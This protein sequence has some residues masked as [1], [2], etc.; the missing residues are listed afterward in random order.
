MPGLDAFS[1][2]SGTLALA[3]QIHDFF[4]NQL[5]DVP[6]NALILSIR[7]DSS[8]LN[9]FARIFDIAIKD[10]NISLSD[11][12]LL[13]EICVALQPSLVYIQGWIIRRQTA[14]LTASATRK[15]ANTVVGF[16]WKQ[17]ELQKVATD[18]L[19]W[20]ER[21]HIRLGLLPFALRERLLA[22]PSQIE[23]QSSLNLRALRETF[24]RL[25][26]QSQL[27]EGDNLKKDES[28]TI[29]RPGTTS[30]TRMLATLSHEN[31]IIEFKGYQSTAG[32]D[33]IQNLESEVLKLL[34]LL[35]C[36]DTPLCRILKGI[37]YFHQPTRSCFAFLYQLP[38]AIYV[39][40]NSSSPMTLL[41]MIKAT[42]KSPRDPTK[43]EL[44][45]PLHPLESRFEFARKIACAVMYTHVMGYVHKS[46]RT[47]NIIVL[48]KDSN[49]LSS[50]AR[51]P[52]RLGEP[53]LCGFETARH[54]K[55]VSDQHGD[56]HWQF[57]IYRH[58]RRQGIHPQDRYT[59]NHDVYSLGVVLLELGL[60]KPLLQTGLSKLQ[61]AT[62]DDIAAGVVRDYLKKL[63]V[64]NLPIILGTKYC[65]TVLFCLNLD[66][67]SQVGSSAVV[68]EVLRKL[69][70]LSVGMQ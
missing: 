45:P 27:V 28:E 9:D 68:E 44:L 16:L 65:E 3:L 49:Q 69:E 37:G 51:F 57:N 7:N 8:V 63:A 33:D 21:Y 61:G 50:A 11:K 56:A 17:A 43:T 18:L 60:W 32:P 23:P 67:D 41:N 24:L 42:R 35:N 29:L 31:V 54:D 20:T 10:Q 22:D 13:A 34:K 55:A 53:F 59:M 26:L 14:N 46:I 40:P 25:N 47:S 5:Q 38:K 2:V 19:Q 30:S 6:I 62:A 1:A 48:D 70:D 15:L 52:K 64:E 66:G 4:Q 58:P 39:D 12:L 36:V